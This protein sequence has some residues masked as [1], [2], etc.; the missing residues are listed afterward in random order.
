MLNL[1]ISINKKLEGANNILIVGAGGGSDVL[2][3]LPLY[4]T[5]LKQGKKVHLA[6]LTHTDYKTIANHADPIILDSVLLGAT[7]TIKTPSTNYVEGYLSQ[8]FKVALNQ[9]HIVWMLNRTHVQELRKS[10][11]RLVEHLKIDAI[12]LVDGG[13]DSI[14]HGDEDGSGT[15][16]EDTLTLAAT[17]DLA[18]P[19]ILACI[20]FGTEAEEGLNHYRALENIS[21]IIKQGGFYGNC[22]L[23]DYMNSFK[24][25][26]A[27]C[28]YI[29]SQPGHKRSHI[30]T[31]IIPAAQG[32]FGN[33]HIY[34]EGENEPIEICINPL[35]N[36][37]WFFEADAAVYNNQIITH[38]EGLPTFYETIQAAVPRIKQIKTRSREPLPFL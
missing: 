30:S 34:H 1:P 7:S 38:I 36:L 13:I 33:V 6:N 26:K 8:Y 14:M 37:Y 17:K 31:R 10:F 32:E 3:G 12:I 35:M 25:Y 19:K 5:F 23:V 11:E 28:E 18:I 2:C 16:F 29:W 22:A 24:F 15:M 9:D 20:G 21:N 4:Y 27:A